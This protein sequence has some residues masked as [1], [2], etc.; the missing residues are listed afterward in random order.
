MEVAMA[1]EAKMVLDLPGGSVQVEG[2]EAFVGSWASGAF[3]DGV[4]TGSRNEVLVRGIDHAWRWFSLHAK[5]RM[6]AVNFFMLGVAFLGAAYVSALRFTRPALA[7]AIGVLG[8]FFAIWFH[9]FEV[10]IRELLHAGEDALVPLE[11]RL[12]DLTGIPALRFSERVERPRYWFTSYNKVIKALHI[13]TGLLF[14]LGVMYGRWLALGTGSQ[15]TGPAFGSFLFRAVLVL[16]GLTAL[17]W[18]QSL[19]RG[20][21][22]PVKWVRCSFAVLLVVVGGAV[23]ILSS[24]FLVG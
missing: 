22:V 20:E 15:A 23:L 10:R 18:G 21:G 4:G 19:I 16:A 7:E 3:K 8:V 12:A 6:Q 5:Q 14:L 13:G 24:L 11:A 17:Y 2:T 9:M 1:T